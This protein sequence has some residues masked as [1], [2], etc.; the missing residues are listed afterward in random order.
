MSNT[1]DYYNKNADAFAKETQLLDFHETQDKFLSYLKVKDQ[2]LDFGCGAGRDTKYFLD[3]GY[4]V[5]AIDGSAKLCKIASQY[6]GIKVKHMYF[7][8]LDE[9]NKYDGIWACSSI[10]HLHKDDLVDVLKKMM[11]ALKP[12][13]IIY[14]S[15]KYGDFTGERHGRYFINFTQESFHS[16]LEQVDGLTIIE[17][18]LTGDVR[19]DRKERWLNVL[20]K[21]AK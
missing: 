1:I 8:E 16:L 6:T 5:E 4:D 21:R 3:H 15:F 7:E 11:K 20:L 2:I 12:N 19:D 14:T 17:E 18:W 10:L 13:G 9:I